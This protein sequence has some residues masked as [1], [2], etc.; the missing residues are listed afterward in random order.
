MDATRKHWRTFSNSSCVFSRNRCSIFFLSENRLISFSRCSENNC[1]L[2][3]TFCAVCTKIHLN[4]RNTAPSSILSSLLLNRCLDQKYPS[5]LPSASVVIIFHN[6]AWSTLLRTVHTVLAR[7]PPDFLKEIILVDD[8]SDFFAYGKESLFFIIIKSVW[9]A[10]WQHVVILSPF[11]AQR[12]RSV[13][14]AA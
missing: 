4:R 10:L 7:S 8:H 13:Q 3:K 12:W 5:N 1:V 9:R 2:E 14:R 6:E 11:Y